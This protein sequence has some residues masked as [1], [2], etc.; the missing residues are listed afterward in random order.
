[1]SSICVIETVFNGGLDIAAK[2]D[3]RNFYF[4]FSTAKAL[5]IIL[6]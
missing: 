6:G 1:M 5:I 4:V 2:I 3:D